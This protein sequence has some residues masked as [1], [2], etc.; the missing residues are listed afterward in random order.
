MRLRHIAFGCTLTGALGCLVLPSA[1]ARAAEGTPDKA[2]L[3]ITAPATVV[4]G[5]NVALSGRLSFGSDAPPAQTPW[6]TRMTC[7]RSRLRPR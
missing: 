4:Y 6:I 7:S 2:T 3:T 5:A 1:T